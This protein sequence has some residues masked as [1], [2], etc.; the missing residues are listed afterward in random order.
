MLGLSVGEPH[1]NWAPRD[2]LHPSDDAKLGD[3]IDV[4][5]LDPSVGA[6][7]WIPVGDRLH[8][9]RGFWVEGT[10]G[11]SVEFD[12]LDHPVYEELMD[13]GLVS[14]DCGLGLDVLLTPMRDW[15]REP[16]RPMRQRRRDDSAVPALRSLFDVPPG[17]TPAPEG[18]LAAAL[19]RSLAYGEGP[20]RLD[21]KL[22]TAVDRHVECLEAMLRRVERGFE[23]GMRDN[24]YGG[25]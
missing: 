7:P 14:L 21:R 2:L 8:V 11:G 9:A 19:L 24:G 25:G 15:L 10:T 1:P 4:K 23:R 6:F 18:S 16:S 22:A 20:E 5:I 12:T 17:W 3:R 13:A